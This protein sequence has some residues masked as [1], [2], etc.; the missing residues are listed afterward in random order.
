MPVVRRARLRAALPR[1]RALLVR[2]GALVTLV[3]LYFSVRGLD[4]HAAWRAAR[5]STPL[6]L[7]PSFGALAAAIVLRAARWRVLF[8]APGRPGLRP[9]LSAYLVGLFFNGILPL[10]A[11]EAA[12][13]VALARRTGRPTAEVT[14]TVVV[15]RLLDVVSL[16]ALLLASAPWLPHLTW[17]RAAAIVAAAAGAGVLAAAVLLLRFGDRP[18]ELL[19]RPLALLPGIDRPRAREA[20]RAAGR[21]LVVLRSPRTAGVACGLT[22]ASWLA[23]AISCW[24]LTLAFHLHLPLLAGLLVVVATNLGQVLPSSPAA[25]GVFEAATLVALS[26]YGVARAPALSYAVFLHVLNLLPF[27]AAGPLALRV[28]PLA[29]AAHSPLPARV[30]GPA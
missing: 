1:P 14:A 18:L 6:W 25:L 4:L 30:R 27:L 10:R 11:G 28:T 22:L 7:L 9:T 5:S 12:R 20:A 19:L 29:P 13:I 3:L 8:A 26:A 2:L 17:L 23:L 21:G 15:E 24:T 16:L